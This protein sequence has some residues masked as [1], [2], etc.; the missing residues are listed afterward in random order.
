M[1]TIDALTRFGLTRQEA[2]VYV[3]LCGEG[4]RN[5]YEIAKETGISRSNAYGALAGLADKGAADT[6]EG[7]P[8]R[9]F[10]VPPQEFCGAK[11]HELQQLGAELA[12]GLVRH[13]GEDGPSYVTVRGLP[14]IAARME[15][16][17][18]SVEE[19][20]YLSVP[21]SLLGP[22]IPALAALVEK[23]RKVVVLAAEPPD[24]PGTIAYRQPEPDA[25]IRLIA[26]SRLVLTGSLAGDVPTCLYSADVHLVDLVKEALRSEIRLVETAAARIQP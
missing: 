24:L 21:A 9:Y 15:A 2:A 25:R 7:S 16:M 19:R 8:V 20:V 23:D 26:D 5:G 13:P 12:A 17:L 1:E 14:R 4:P 11:I 10:A 22:M 3:R 6:E 18:D